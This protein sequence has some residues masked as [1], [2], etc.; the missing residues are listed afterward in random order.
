MLDSLRMLPAPPVRFQA[1]LE[2]DRHHV[3]A[4]LAAAQGMIV[5]SRIA[6]EVAP[7]D[8]LALMEMP[9]NA[10]TGTP[11]LAPAR[12]RWVPRPASA[13]P[14]WAGDTLGAIAE[15]GHWLAVGAVEAGESRE[16]HPGDPA[17]VR[18]PS[19][20]HRELRGR[21]ELVRRAG[22]DPRN[23]ATVAVE[24][25][26]PG[27]AEDLGPA[28]EVTVTP[29]DPFDSVLAAPRNAIAQLSAGPAVFLALGGGRYEVRFVSSGPHVGGLVVLRAG[30]DHRVTIVSTGRELVARMAEESLAVRARQ[31][32]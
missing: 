1:L 2:P 25:N 11:I 26:D 8:T 13:E 6:G 14:R 23:G 27:R 9:G 28:V 17:G 29:T 30:V 3:R 24:F 16:I 31:S 32:P 7:G 12:G 18:L 22:N 20:P 19:V 5:H 15:S 10:V 4:V 21:V